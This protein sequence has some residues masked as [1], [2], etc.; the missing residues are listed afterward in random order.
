VFVAVVACGLA[1]GSWLLAR[2]RT[3][4]SVAPDVSASAPTSVSV[5]IPARN[6]ARALPVVLRS[7]AAQTAPPG[8]VIVVDDESTDATA[9]VAAAH[10]A[11]VLSAGPLPDA[12]AGKAHACDVGARAA[13]ARHVLFLD[14]DV[15]LAPDALARLHALHAAVGGLVSVQPHHVPVRGYEQLS[16][17]CNVVAL[18]G[19]GLFSPHPPRRA[20]AAFGPCLFTA[21]M[22]YWRAGGH[23]AAP[24]SVVE[25]LA[26]AAA[27]DR[28]ALPVTCVTGGEH[29]R[30]RM[31]PDGP[32]QL[33]EGWSKNLAAGAT[34]AD[35]R[36]VT[37][38]VLW[39]A[40]QLAVTARLARDLT[41]WRRGHTPFPIATVATAGVVAAQSRRLQ[42]RAGTFRW[43]TAFAFPVPLTAFVALFTRSW[44][45]TAVRHTVTWRDRTLPARG[46][47]CG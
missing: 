36:A 6:E 17:Y 30:F 1:V 8:E 35:P 28:V 37:G 12:W 14:A 32:R 22:D 15:E 25:D 2:I 42:R 40:A 18:M 24:G 29:V 27:Y 41:R 16:A 31:Y 3:L 46:R 47:A 33:V 34:G 19:T 10:G 20:R 44:W 13:T 9:A 7:L 43:W 23:A 39:I 45:C 11:R 21:A 4:S 5:V 26:L 38:T